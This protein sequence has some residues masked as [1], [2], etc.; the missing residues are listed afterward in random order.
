ME[1]ERYSEPG[2]NS[3]ITEDQEKSFYELFD[4][5]PE[6][7]F[8]L[9]GDI[10]FKPN[11]STTEK[12]V[13]SSTAYSDSDA[14][15]LLG[16]KSRV[17]AAAEIGKRF[18]DSLLIAN[19]RS[20]NPEKPTH[21]SVIASELCKYGIPE[22]RIIQQTESTTTVAEIVA[23]IK[24]IRQNGWHNVAVVSNEYHLPRAQIFWEKINTMDIDDPELKEAIAYCHQ[25]KIKINFIPAETI[26][27]Y[28]DK[29]YSQLITEMKKT[30]VYQKRLENERIGVQRIERGEYI[31]DLHPPGDKEPR[32]K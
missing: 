5:Q 31:I 16:G 17:I 32:K 2:P 15:G 28:R 23:L 6:A 18:S 10:K 8:I 3:E 29:R 4:G 7:V 25:E 27:P 30:E 19:S 1:K 13:Y 11:A 12:S 9:S 20:S 21:A 14:F 24:L 22:K 26:L